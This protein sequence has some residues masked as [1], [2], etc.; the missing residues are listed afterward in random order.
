ML[1]FLLWLGVSRHWIFCD[2]NFQI[3]VF[4]KGSINN[5]CS[6]S[7]IVTALNKLSYVLSGVFYWEILVQPTNLQCIWSPFLCN[8]LCFNFHF[9]FLCLFFLLLL[10]GYSVSSVQKMA[11]Y[12]IVSNFKKICYIFLNP[13]KLGTILHNPPPP[14]YYV[15]IHIYID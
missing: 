4:R 14:F 1:F 15:S 9:P 6:T 13:T 12:N 11:L 7:L 5:W 10:N 8:F 2:D 3:F